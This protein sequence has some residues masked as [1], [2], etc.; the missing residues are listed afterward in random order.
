MKILL[1]HNYYQQT[2]G[3]DVVVHSEKKLL[4]SFGHQVF[5]TKFDNQDIDSTISKVKNAFSL[6]FSNSSK[7]I[8]I[9]DIKKFCPDIVHVHNFF[10]QITPS[11]YDACLKTGVPVVQTLHNFRTICASAT[12][13]RK[14]KVCEK[15]L[16]SSPYWAAFHRCYR[17]SFAGSLAVARMISYHNREMT[18]KKKINHFIAL[19]NFGKEKFKE[20]HFAEHKISVKPNFIEVFSDSQ[21]FSHPKRE[22]TALFVGR[23]SHEKGINTLIKAWEKIDFRLEIAGDGPLF[24]D[25]KKFESKTIKFLGQISKK[26]VQEK[27][28]ASSFLIMPSIWYETF[29]LVII[30]AFANG[31]PVIASKMGSMEEI[32]ENGKTGLLFEPG[33]PI[34]L[35]NKINELISSPKLIKQMSLNAHNE[36]IEKYTP[37]QNYAMLMKIYKNAIEEHVSLMQTK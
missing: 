4:Q 31:L 27:M 30:E 14:H 1:I 19:T 13:M 15:C 20:A 7:N 28:K 36:Y 11:V 10:P 6:P 34:D 12:F 18:W 37:K 35:A 33:N 22:R 29:G 24:E 23:L 26:K 21:T 3:E 2:G 32:I 9:K 8:I 16:T 5:L 25:Y 17:N